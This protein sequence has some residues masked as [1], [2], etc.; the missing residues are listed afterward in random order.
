MEKLPF[1]VVTYINGYPND[2]KEFANEKSAQEW[3][4]IQT[5][6]YQKIRKAGLTTHS[7]KYMVQH[8]Y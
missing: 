1:R 5:A 6:H 3:A 8:N 4:G 7:Y 2:K